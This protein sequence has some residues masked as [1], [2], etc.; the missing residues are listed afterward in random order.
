M[1]QRH[2]GLRKL[3]AQQLPQPLFM[4]RVGVGMEQTYG[5]AFNPCRFERSDSL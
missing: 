3:V 1:R 4:G 2:I 5:D